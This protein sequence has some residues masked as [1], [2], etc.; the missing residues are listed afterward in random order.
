VQRSITKMVT[1]KRLALALLFAS[2]QALAQTENAMDG[3]HPLL[4]AGITTGGDTIWELEYEDGDST[5]IKGGNLFQIGAGVQYR[6]PDSPIDVVLSANY[7]VD[8][9][10][11]SNGKAY[12]KRYPLE[13]VAYYRT[14]ERWRFG[15]GLRYVLSPKANLD[16]DGFGG[17]HQRFEFDNAVGVVGEAGFSLTKNMWLNLRFVNESYTLNS[18]NGQPAKGPDLDGSHAG[19]NLLLVF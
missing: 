12:F 5:E 3:W 17:T 18:A 15:L 13:A 14:A 4:S 8:M 7:H 16:I 1:G 10:N 9:S 2:G 6:S 19:L 11:A